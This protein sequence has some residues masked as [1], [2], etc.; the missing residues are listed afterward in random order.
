MKLTYSSQLEWDD[1]L[2]LATYCYNIVPL[3]DG[4]ESPFILV[5]GPLEGR[6]SN[7]HNYCRYMVDQP[8]RLVVQELQRTFQIHAKPLVENRSTKPAINKK[9]TKG[10]D[11]KIGQLILIKNHWKGPFVPTYIYNHLVAG[12]PT[13]AQY[14]LCEGTEYD[15]MCLSY[16]SPMLF[17]DNSDSPSIV[18]Q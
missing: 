18:E 17:L 16:C 15:V 8:G 14:Y 4:L 3:V 11:L 6:L 5:F 12:I 13:K 9:V 10:S 2:P 7:I 1:V